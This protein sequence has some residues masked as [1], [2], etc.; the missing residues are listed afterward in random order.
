ML[1]Q[2]VAI[3]FWFIEDAGIHW[4]PI[5]MSSNVFPF[6]FLSGVLVFFRIYVGISYPDELQVVSNYAFSWNVHAGKNLSIL[7][8]LSEDTTLL[9]KDFTLN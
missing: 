1:W 4:G 9:R 3:V 6:L 7:K 2:E 8:F 5:E